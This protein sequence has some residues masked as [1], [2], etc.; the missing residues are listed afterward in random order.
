MDVLTAVGG[1]GLTFSVRTTLPED[2]DPVEN[3]G[4][5]RFL[6]QRILSAFVVV[7]VVVVVSLT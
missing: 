7:V 6:S 4:E 5:T 1:S 3:A 2:V